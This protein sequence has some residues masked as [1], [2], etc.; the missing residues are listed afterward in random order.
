MASVNVSNNLIDHWLNGV[1]ES[2][3]RMTDADGIVA[4]PI[5]D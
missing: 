3:H 4:N 2:L 5:G 1:L